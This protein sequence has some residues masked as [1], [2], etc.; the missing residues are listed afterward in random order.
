[1][2]RAVVESFPGGGGGHAIAL[3]SLSER[4]DNDGRPYVWMCNS[5]GANWGN[6]GWSEWAPKAIEQMCRHRYTVPIGVS[7]MPNAKPREFTL[8]DWKRKLKA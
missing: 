4:K 2:S 3:L 6:N 7:D 5:W 1:M 8:D